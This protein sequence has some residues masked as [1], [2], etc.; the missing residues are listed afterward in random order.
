MV[1]ISVFYLTGSS[2]FNFILFPNLLACLDECCTWTNN[3]ARLDQSLV[4]KI[5]ILL[6]IMVRIRSSDNAVYLSWKIKKKV[7][8]YTRVSILPNVQVSK[9]QVSNYSGILSRDT[10]LPRVFTR[11]VQKKEC[12]RESGSFSL[13]FHVDEQLRIINFEKAI[14]KST[15]FGVLYNVTHKFS[16]GQKNFALQ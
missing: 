13:R 8:N 11:I 15:H 12:I 3:T 1:D 7:L 16:Y 6:R 14:Q 10:A 4:P 5:L 9:K 2:F